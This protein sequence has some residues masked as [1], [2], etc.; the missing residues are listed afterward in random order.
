M[1]ET[2]R[3]AAEDERPG[4]GPI[5]RALWKIFA[6]GVAFTSVIIVALMVSARQ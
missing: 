2:V 4:P 3:F 6:W 1:R 5:L